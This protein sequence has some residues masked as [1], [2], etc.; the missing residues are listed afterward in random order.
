MNSEHPTPHRFVD[1]GFPEAREY[2][3][4]YRDLRPKPLSSD[5]DPHRESGVFKIQHLLERAG[6]ISLVARLISSNPN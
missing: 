2:D 6:L 5:E 4:N 1:D 3:N